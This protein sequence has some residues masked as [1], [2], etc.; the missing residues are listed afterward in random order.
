[1]FIA[2]VGKRDGK[3]F[4][5]TQSF[6]NGDLPVVTE[7]PA[8]VEYPFDGQGAYSSD[9]ELT[10]WGVTLWAEAQLEALFMHVSALEESN[11]SL[12]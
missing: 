3:F 11:A 4:G 9:G 5:R 8:P 10:L 12:R 1:M 7:C 2:T 6:Q